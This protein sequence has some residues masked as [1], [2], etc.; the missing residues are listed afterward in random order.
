MNAG[1]LASQD[2]STYFVPIGNGAEHG[3]LRL[4]ANVVMRSQAV[5]PMLASLPR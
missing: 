4:I 1:P 5:P 3:I 2:N